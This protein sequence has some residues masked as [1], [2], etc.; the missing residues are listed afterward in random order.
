MKKVLA[1]SSVLLGVVFL[2]G[3][4]QQ[5]VSQTQP[6]TP[7]PVAQT[8]TQ[9]VATQQSTD[10]TTVSKNLFTNPNGKYSFELPSAWK[11]AINKYN[12]SNSLFGTNADSG[13]GLGGVEIF[14]NQVSIDKF[15]E[16]VDAQYSN[17]VKI[18][19]DGIS[20]I[21]THYKGFPA[22]GEQAVLL[23]NGKI[24]NIY[25]NSEK[26]EDIKLLEQIFTTFKF[27]E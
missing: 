10:S 17:K 23:K 3:C 25:V 18:T 27:T 22:S 26:A 16:S 2:A 9:P 5:P 19:I 21:R 7:A 12:N 13:S 15:L 11:V 20:G 4:G 24:Y 6:T 1:I 8:P 14:D